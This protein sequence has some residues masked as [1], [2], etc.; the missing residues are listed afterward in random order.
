VF[1]LLLQIC[2]ENGSIADTGKKYDMDECDLQLKM[3]NV[4]TKGVRDTCYA[5]SGE[6]EA[7]SSIGLFY[8]MRKENSYYLI[9]CAAPH[10]CS[11]ETKGH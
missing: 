7:R 3:N 10:S 4:N 8:E 11:T 2:Q 1:A 6:R 5:T 9:A